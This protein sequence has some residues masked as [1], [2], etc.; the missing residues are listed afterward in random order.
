[1]T[2]EPKTVRLADYQPPDYLVDEVE[3]HFDLTDGHADVHSRLTCRR[4]PGADAAAPL[5]LDGEE[6]T[7]RAIALDGCPLGSG[8]YQLDEA[9]LVIPSAPE[10]FE[11][12]LTT[13]VYPDRNTRLEGL[14][15]SGGMYCTQCEAQGFRRITFFPDRPDVMARYTVTLAADR[16]TCPVLLSNGNPVDRGELDDGR[17]WVRWEDPFPKPS[18]LFALV[19]GDLHCHEASYQTGSGR[20]IRLA[21]YTEH[22]NAG[23]TEHAMNSL[24]AAMRWD[25]RAYGLECDLDHYMIV[26]VGDFNMGAMENKGLNIF[27][28]QY[29]LARPETATDTDY[30][31]IEAVIGHEYFHNWTGNRVTLRDWFQLSLKEGLTVFREQQFS[32]AMGAP[33]V[34]RIDEVRGLRAAQFPEDAGPMAHPVRPAE[35]VEINNFYTATVYMKGAEVIRMYH[36]LLG[37]DGFRR[38]I[39]LYF[40]RHDGQAVTCEDF[41]AAM[42]DANDADLEQFSRWYRQ[43]GTPV[44]TVEEEWDAERGEYRLHFSQH[45]G[46]TPGQSRKFPLH[47]PILI[48][49]VGADGRDLVLRPDGAPAGDTGTH[50]LELRHERASFTY[51]GL[52]ERPVPSLFRGFSA[53]VRVDY[54]YDDEQLAFLFA[55]DSDDFNRWEAG[56]RLAT[57]ILL[58][59]VA[60]EPAETLPRLFLD[61]FRRIL[62]SATLD[63]ALAAEALTLP[64][65]TYLAEQ[66][67]IA[68]AAAIHAARQAM[69]RA[70]AMSLPA[71]LEQAYD[72]CTVTGPY[73]PESTDMALR[74]LRNVVL[75][76]RAA[77]GDDAALQRCLTQFDNADNM[78]DALPALALLAE[79]DAAAATER[80][81]AFHERWRD[82][83]LVVDKWFRVQATARR[84]DTL[85]RVK[86][87]TAH[88]AFDIRNP[89]K[90]RALI[91]SFCQGNPAC[92]HDASGAGYTFLADHILRLDGINPQV[93]ARL[94]T[95]LTRWRR[96]DEQR[97]R[98]M[99]AELE[100]IAQRPQLSKDVHE[101]V[102]KSLEQAAQ[103]G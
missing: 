90:L 56:Q 81:N 101:V 73:R 93:A 41:L 1:M 23:K 13:R 5:V 98:L 10:R 60:D 36:T 100:R 83:P 79:F 74:R 76:Y 7:L 69:R 6:L 17:H 45:T 53:P 97:A 54:P 28:T 49:L 25:E 96:Q 67:D 71:E 52:S 34:K 39:D 46:P 59:W 19:A 8:D 29:V 44:V 62:T 22:A 3:L 35:F 94:L 85:D 42:A 58:R 80:L 11:L 68:D 12:T 55:H 47:I 92:F 37:D 88:E 86:A 4:R 87:L 2:T 84:P 102:S 89:N 30:I 77:P 91:G 27:N 33:A 63:P 57:R 43:A 16:A 99:R 75:D 14:Y 50:L 26:A 20:D 72:R 65:E 66:M 48:G 18:Y 95:P 103:T 40:Q 82:E 9:R 38:G 24:Q 31:N 51:S 15:R 78:T 21:I 32:A 64:T 70:I 61:A